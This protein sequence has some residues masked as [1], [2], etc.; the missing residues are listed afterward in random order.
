MA[1]CLVFFKKSIYHSLSW[2]VLILFLE[3]G[4]HLSCS[5]GLDFL[6]PSK[7]AEDMADDAVNLLTRRIT[8][9][10]IFKVLW[11]F[12]F[13]QLGLPSLLQLILFG[14]SNQMVVT[15]KEENTITFKHLFLK[16]YADGSDD[17]HAV[18]T[19]ADVYDHI[20]HAV[21]NVRFKCSR[22]GR[23]HMD[24]L[25]LIGLI[26]VMIISPYSIWPFQVRQ[27]DAMPMFTQ[28]MLTNQPSCSASNITAREE[29]TQP[30]ILSTLIPRS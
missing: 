17:T 15:F 22:R 12:N 1:L 3:R 27:L 14:L 24:D 20:F 29:L 21:E 10:A 7:G 25:E 23:G 16:N 2:V 30:M 28:T 5:Q 13:L 6:W 9:L 11:F 8:F 19:Q 4:R 26:L 18:Y